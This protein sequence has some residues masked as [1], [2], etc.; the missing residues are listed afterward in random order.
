MRRVIGLTSALAALLSAPLWAQD[1]QDDL[2]KQLEDLRK[3]VE[4]LKSANTT[5]PVDP[6]PVV[7]AK[8]AVA[9]EG[10]RMAPAQEKKDSPLMTL[11]KETKVSGFVDAGY[12]YNRRQPDSGTNAMRAFDYKSNS[13]M[14]HNAQLNF[15]R[16]ATAEM[17]AGFR[18]E[19]SAG[20]DAEIFEAGSGEDLQVAEDTDGDGFFD[21]NRSGNDGDL[22]DV[23]EAYAQLLIPQVKGLE[24]RVGKFATLAGYEVIESKDNMNYSRGL[25]FT[26]AI[27]FTHTGARVIYQPIDQLKLTLGYVNGWDNLTDNNNSKTWEFQVNAT[28]MAGLSLYAN[29]YYGAEQ[30]DEDG[31]KRVLFD[32]VATYTVEKL[33]VGFNYDVASEDYDED[34]VSQYYSET[35]EWN[36]WAAYAKYQVT[37]TVSGALRFERFRDQDAYRTGI[38]A[39]YTS[40]TLTLEY[41]P[42]DS[43]IFR[44]EYRYDKVSDGDA[45]YFKHGHARTQYDT[46]GFEAIVLF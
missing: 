35:A 27:P 43:I 30:T 7:P 34:E 16:L 26:W 42:V 23:Q 22:F 39:N 38:H 6:D 12:N 37:D 41:K 45:V 31:N 13:F 24:I 21:S 4:A 2:R 25:L 20:T 8:H 11:F 15:E 36:G 33:T 5:K 18:I 28:P 32:F 46:I 14:L 3:E 10:E 44:V 19:L 29:I 1:S 40:L 17:V 9:P